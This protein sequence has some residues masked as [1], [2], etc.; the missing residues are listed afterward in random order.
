MSEISVIVHDPVPHDIAPIDA[1]EMKDSLEALGYH[2]KNV[3]VR[4]DYPPPYW[5]VRCDIG[6]HLG[7]FSSRLDACTAL[8][9]VPASAVNWE[10]LGDEE[11]KTYLDVR[12]ER[13]RAMG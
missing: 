13:R 4:Q 2:V 1:D 5:L 12:D 10:V 9:L 8:D 11:F 6:K 7:P 3:L